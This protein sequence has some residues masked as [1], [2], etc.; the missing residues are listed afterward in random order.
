M[1]K[2]STKQIT[3]PTNVDQLDEW[4]LSELETEDQTDE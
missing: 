4:L 2:P 1:H 3:L